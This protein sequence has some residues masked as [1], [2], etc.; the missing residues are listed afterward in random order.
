MRCGFEFTI[1]W[2]D[3]DLYEVRVVAWSGEFGGCAETYV[4]IGGFREAADKLRG[5][6]AN[7]D[8][9]RTLQFGEF[10]RDTAGGAVAMNFFSKDLSGHIRVEARLESDHASGHVQSVHLLAPIEAAAVD[11]F[12][13]ELQQLEANGKGMAFLSSC[14]S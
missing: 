13:E 14:N 8:D 2:S 3:V 4:T 11:S 7:L 6:P 1:L 5:F 9:N 10:G 12:V